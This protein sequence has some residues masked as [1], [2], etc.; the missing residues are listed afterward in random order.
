[1]SSTSSTS[2]VIILIFNIS[3]TVEYFFIT[4]F[5]IAPIN[6]L[7]LDSLSDY[8]LLNKIFLIIFKSSVYKDLLLFY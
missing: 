3:I 8:I 1:M 7:I 6:L 4:K 5:Y 2:I